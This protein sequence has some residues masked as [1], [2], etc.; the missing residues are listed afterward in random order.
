[1][2]VDGK[3]TAKG[4]AAEVR[5]GDPFSIYV[6]PTFNAKTLEGLETIA[7]ELTH[8]DQWRRNP[9]DIYDIAYQWEELW[10]GYA[11][12]VFENEARAMERLIGQLYPN[13]DLSGVVLR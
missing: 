9:A 12:N 7:H 13:V 5:R 2:V 6:D 11:G 10:H 3:L 1:M 8:M 4:A